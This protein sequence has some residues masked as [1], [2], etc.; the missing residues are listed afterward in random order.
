MAVSTRGPAI[1]FQFATYDGGHMGGQFNVHTQ[2]AFT[3][4]SAEN[5]R[6]GRPARS[7]RSVRRLAVRVVATRRIVRPGGALD[8]SQWHCQS[9]RKFETYLGSVHNI[10]KRI[11]KGEV[12]EVKEFCSRYASNTMAYIGPQARLLKRMDLC[13]ARA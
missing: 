2:S 12:C 6:H 13:K 10:I 11:K 7:S 1:A 5:A 4:T 3:H 9:A 8:G